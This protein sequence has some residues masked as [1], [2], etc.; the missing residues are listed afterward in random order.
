MVGAKEK[1]EEGAEFNPVR[2]SGQVF[3]LNGVS[4]G[5]SLGFGKRTS[6][7]ISSAKPQ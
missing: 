5:K 4:I 1:G 6:P 7:F 3:I 2:A